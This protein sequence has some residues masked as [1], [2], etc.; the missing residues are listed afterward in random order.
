MKGLKAAPLSNPPLFQRS[1][2]LGESSTPCLESTDSQRSC[3]IKAFAPTRPLQESP[4]PFRPGIG[5]PAPSPK[6]MKSQQ[7]L[8]SLQKTI[9]FQTPDTVVS[10]T[11]GPAPGD[12]LSEALWGFLARRAQEASVRADN[13]FLKKFLGTTGIRGANH[14]FPKQRA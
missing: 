4:G 3:R 8:L 12:S 6:I 2:L 11:F 5:L 13:W 7:S 1:D 9:Q 10:D 14:R